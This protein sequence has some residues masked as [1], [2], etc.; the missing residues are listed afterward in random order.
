MRRQRFLDA[1]AA[2]RRA[3]GGRD[4]AGVGVVGQASAMTG[5][6]GGRDRGAEESG[7]LAPL[8]GVRR[9]NLRCVVAL[10]HTVWGRRAWTRPRC[11]SRPPMV[12]C[13]RRLAVGASAVRRLVETHRARR[14][15]RWP[16]GWAI[17]GGRATRSAASAGDVRTWRRCWGAPAVMT[18]IRKTFQ[19][20]GFD[21]LTAIERRNR[22]KTATGLAYRTTLIFDYPIL[23]HRHRHHLGQQ[24]TSEATRTPTR[25]GQCTREARSRRL[26]RRF[27]S[28][29]SERR[30][31]ST[32]SSTWRG[33]PGPPGH[34][35]TAISE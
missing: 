34:S 32:S 26:V 30:D 13:R 27:R 21:W 3:G 18:S 16:S 6:L 17:V 14:S 33:S 4:F 12:G 23:T 15:R 2:Y 7:G 28:D 20:L 9:W 11:G 8:S 1:V 29:D 22:L 31:V 10:L 5:H 19:D 35:G 24:L 25:P